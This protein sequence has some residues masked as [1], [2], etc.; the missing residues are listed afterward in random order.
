MTASTLTFSLSVFVQQKA[1]KNYNVTALIPAALKPAEL[2]QPH[3]RSVLTAIPIQDSW[4][5]VP[6]PTIYQPGKPDTD[7]QKYLCAA[8]VL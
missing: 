7:L 4:K 3:I 1:T 8:V 5:P 2:W 6:A